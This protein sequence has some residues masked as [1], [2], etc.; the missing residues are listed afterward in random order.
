[1]NIKLKL[2]SYSFTY[3]YIN[4]LFVI[5]HLKASKQTFVRYLYILINVYVMCALV[6]TQTSSHIL[7]SRT[8]SQTWCINAHTH[9]RM[10]IF[11]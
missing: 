8:H 11:M 4:E 6:K 2:L 10:D 9:A 5:K 7:L 1:M 3:V